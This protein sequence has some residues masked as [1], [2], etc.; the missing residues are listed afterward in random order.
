MTFGR[1]LPCLLLLGY[2]L[3]FGAASFGVALP[4]FDDHPGQLYRLWHVLEHG[5]APWTWNPGWWAGYPELQFYP[6]G[7]FYLGALLHY[8]AL[9]LLPLGATYQTLLW[10]SYL[11][12]GV[13]TF[14]A[15]ARLLGNGWLALP[16][17][18]A[19]LT[20]SAGLASGVEGGVH[21]G[22]LPARLGWAL[23]PLL[24]LALA[25]WIDDD[26]PPPWGAG[27][28][29][30]AIVLVHP[31]HLPAAVALVA[32]AALSRAGR[33]RRLLGALALLAVAA[34]L[35]AF[36]T[37]PLIARLA[38]TRALAWGR[39]A[40]LETLG[41]HPLLVALLVLAALAPRLA[42]SPAERVI[43]CWPWVAIAVVA[44][45][46]G[47]LEPLGIRWLPA[48][49]ISDGAWLAVILAGGLAGGRLIT[50]AATARRWPIAGLTAAALAATALLGVPGKTLSL[51]PRAAEW[52]SY[53][54][55]ARG[56][57][58]DDFWTAL[59][60]GPEGRVLFLRSGIPLAYGTEWW[61]PHSHVTAL[62]P[63]RAGRD[64]V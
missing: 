1:S 23:L 4:A 8:G 29:V 43:A 28:L 50:R 57:R 22:M 19:A 16:G 25:R 36:W 52:P 62:T 59:R 17:G 24:F 12:P 56:L 7:F 41:N 64:I 60:R 44:L 48:D 39:L 42:R 63:M 37:L 27:V 14:L 18:F 32:L 3:A 49:R 53:A 20:L 46:A 6:P 33:G 5:L 47:A 51:W 38:N 11:A 40:P 55:T 9:A 45:D 10:L 34:A 58:L 30:A 21:I 26:G 2:G 35:T 31:A 15:L 13:T 61:R 54:G